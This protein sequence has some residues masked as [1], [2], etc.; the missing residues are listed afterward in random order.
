MH[1][2]SHCPW[3]PIQE[4]EVCLWQNS[5][6]FIGVYIVLILLLSPLTFY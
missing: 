4:G 5:H 6:L 3:R 2:N 1:I